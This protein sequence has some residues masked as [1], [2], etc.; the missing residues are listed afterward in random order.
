M[1][2]LLDT[3]TYQQ[4]RIAIFVE[5]KPQEHMGEN[6]KNKNHYEYW[7]KRGPVFVYKN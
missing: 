1:P 5:Q 2:Y 4:K 6:Q 7:R 3:I